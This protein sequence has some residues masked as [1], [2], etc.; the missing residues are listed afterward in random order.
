MKKIYAFVFSILLVATMLVMSVSAGEYSDYSAPYCTTAPTIDGTV[1]DGEWDAAEWANIANE[2]EGRTDVNGSAK[3]KVMHDDVNVYI[4]FDIVDETMSDWDNVGVHF[5]DIRSEDAEG[6]DTY[7]PNNTIGI[8]HLAANS[9]SDAS[10]DKG[11]NGNFDA[12]VREGANLVTVVAQKGSDTA[13]GY[14][15]ELKLEYTGGV[16][17]SVYF[18]VSWGEANGGRDLFWNKYWGWNLMGLSTRC[19]GNLNFA[20]KQVEDNND[21]NDNIAGNPETFDA[22]LMVVAVAAVSGMGVAVTKKTR[23]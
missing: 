2:M 5:S 19:Y 10:N 20:A 12:P 3:F 6:A 18:N 1:S 22:V 4:L 9:F 14:L 23:R 7:G 15:I 17:A 8:R 11:K 16:P 13:N 21:N